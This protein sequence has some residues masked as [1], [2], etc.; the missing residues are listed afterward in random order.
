LK[1]SEQRYID[2][3]NCYN[4][5]AYPLLYSDFSKEV[6]KIDHNRESF[7]SLLL[8]LV[9]NVLD[10]SYDRKNQYFRKQTSLQR[11]RWG[12]ESDIHELIARTFI[13][14]AYFLIHNK[15]DR[16]SDTYLSLIKRGSDPD[17]RFYWGRIKN[18]HVVIENTSMVIGLLLNEEKLWDRLSCKEKKNFSKY[19][20]ESLKRE[21]HFNN[22][23]WFKIFHYLFLEMYDGTP[24]RDKIKSELA[25]IDSLYR[26]DGWYGDDTEKYEFRYDHYNS[27]AMHYYGLLFC[28]LAGNEYDDIKEVLKRR[29][30]EFFAHYINLFSAD[31][32][33]IAW[34]RSLIYRFAMLSCFGLG[35][36]LE[37]INQDEWPKVKKLVI[38][39]INRFFE[40]G[41]LDSK[42]FLTMG[43]TKPLISVLEY[44]SGFGS[45]YWACK[46]FSILLLDPDH[47]F[48][49]LEVEKAQC[50][51]SEDNISSIRVYIQNDGKGQNLMINGGIN[52][53]K[54]PMKYNRFAYSD[55]FTQI[56]AGDFIDHTFVF[57]YR[58]KR[59][60]KNV[61]KH[62]ESKPNNIILVQW[63]NDQ[64]E[65]LEV[66]STILP[67]S[68][69]YVMISN[70]IATY[71]MRYLYSGFNMVQ[72][73][74]EVKRSHNSIEL[75]SKDFASKI[76]TIDTGGHLDYK[77]LPR[78]QNLVGKRSGVP[79]VRS[80]IRRESTRTIFC[81]Q[82]C[83]NNKDISTPDIQC[84]SKAVEVSTGLKKIYLE[85]KQNFYT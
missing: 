62:V 57:I 1:I 73:V 37:L 43:Y 2:L 69:G 17:S 4:K 55:T 60:I 58:G 3:I 42:G 64:L 9:N 16:L 39:T 28:Y 67:V 32:L 70:I 13:G 72:K 22:W 48:W 29:F 54:F 36:A 47:L 76:V 61:I 24:C 63:G 45:P 53:C 41:I 31:K 75:I 35:I 12:I 79:F 85:E 8:F 51:K 11:S 44:Y 80:E 7:E 34:G 66:Y 59:F 6:P 19:I 33:P 18:N 81:V 84:D 40:K 78:D 49:K 56:L 25:K 30:K 10:H 21:F 27:W 50:V 68:S 20:R 82:A 14:V 26:G 52:S 65:K 74:E 5:I 46:A 38:S 77:L 15:S 71:K 83:G 23:L